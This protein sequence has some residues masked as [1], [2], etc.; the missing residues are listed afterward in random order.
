[1]PTGPSR[2]F[3]MSMA[4][5]AALPAPVF[6]ASGVSPPKPFGATPSPRQL[7]WSRL[8]AYAFVHFT[9]NTFTDRE[10]GTG[11]ESPS[12]FNPTDFSADQIVGAAKAGGL[13]AVMLTAK[14]HDGFCLWPSA[15]TEHSVKN[16]PYKDGKGDIVREMAEACAR[17]GLKFGVYLS[18]WDRNHADYGRPAYVTYYHNQL[19]ELLSGYGPLFEVWFDGAN[20]GDGY[21]GGARETRSIDG[22]TYYDWPGITKIVRDLQPE[23]VTF[24]YVGSDIRWVGNENGIAGETCWSTMKDPLKEDADLD[25]VGVLGG[26]LWQPAECD[27]SIRPGWFWHEAQNAQVKSPAALMKLYFESVG[28]GCGLILNLPPDRRGRICDE[29][30]RSLTAWAEARQA[31][32]GANLA[33]GARAR[34]SSVR[35]GDPAYAGGKVLDGRDET[36]WTPG[37]GVLAAELALDLE[38]AKTFD[39][40]RVREALPLGQ[41]VTRFALDVKTPGGWTQAAQATSIGSQRLMRLSAP[42]TAS[43]VRLRILGAVAPPAISEV[44]LFRFPSL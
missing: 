15:Y 12:V 22:A 34:A 20:G 3:L 33:E 24:N 30:V 9:V 10:W 23:A 29:D 40:I 39:V 35:G 43:A 41:R 44:G 26:P 31:M 8:E 17:Q 37:D 11:E 27:V 38:G 6:A 28:R 32:F 36:Y 19:R 1:M 16:S 18:P 13:K 2:R 7:A 42:V 21:Y 4:A 25:N 5:A 14:H